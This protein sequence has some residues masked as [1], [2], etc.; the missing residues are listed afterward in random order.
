[1]RCSIPIPASIPPRPPTHRA[2]Q[3]STTRLRPAPGLQRP[4]HSRPIPC[5]PSKL[6]TMPSASTFRFRPVCPSP[7][8]RS[9]SGEPPCRPSVTSPRHAS[10]SCRRRRAARRSA[11]RSRPRR[12]PVT[13]TPRCRSP[14]RRGRCRSSRVPDIATRCGRSSSRLRVRSAGPPR[15]S[16][17][18]ADCRGAP[19]SYHWTMRFYLTT[20]IYYVNSTPHIGHA[21]T[22]AIG[23]MIVRNRRQRG[24]ETFF[25]TGVDEHATKVFRVA[26]EQGLAPQEYAD[27]IAVP[28]QELPKRLNAQTDFF[29]RTSD[30]GHKRFV[31]EFLQRMYDNGDIYEDVY[32]GWYCVGCEAFKAEEELTADGLCPDHLV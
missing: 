6:S 1:R 32:A 15:R 31:R 11:P 5:P 26:Q 19:P 12:T 25:L 3:R 28:W 18:G 4:P 21:Y 2:T 9:R 27:Q 29:I 16:A 14:R 20:P 23:D 17:Y 30:E 13:L 24:Q 7:P 10:L 22:T 8:E